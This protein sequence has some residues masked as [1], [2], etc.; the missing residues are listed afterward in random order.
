INYKKEDFEQAL[1]GTTINVVLDMV[2][3]EY[4]PKN[5]RLL[6]TDGRLMFINSMQ[7]ADS[8][9]HIPTMMQ[10]R[11]TISGSMLK[12]RDDDFKAAL[13]AAIQHHVWPLL[14][15]GRLKPIVYRTFPLAEAAQAQALLESSEHIGKI[16][17]EVE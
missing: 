15:D 10:K 2:G 12:P 3:G 11:L 13:T 8:Q 7:G 16:I 1:Q 5:L 14:A 4:T 17:L 6:A 9:I